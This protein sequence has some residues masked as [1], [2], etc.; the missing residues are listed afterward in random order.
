MIEGMVWKTLLE[1]QDDGR[2]GV[3]DV[4]GAVGCLGA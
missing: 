4:L 3:E 2:D 1:L